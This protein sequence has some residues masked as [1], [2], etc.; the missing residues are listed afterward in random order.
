MEYIEVVGAKEHNLKNVDVKI[1]RNKFVVIT[2]LSG[3]GKSTLAFDIIYAEGQR[4]YMESLSSYARQFLGQMNKPKVESISGLSPA[5]SIE[6]KGVSKNPRSTVGTITEIYDYLRVFFARL[7]TIRCFK[8]GKVISAVSVD[9]ILQDIQKNLSLDDKFVILS[10]IVLSRKGEYKSLFESLKDKG[11]IRVRVDGEDKLLDEKITLKKNIK[12]NISVVIDRLIY[13]NEIESRLSESVETAL[14]L[15]DGLVEIEI[16]GKRVLLYSEKLHCIDCGIGFQSLSPRN[17]SF[18]SPYGAC[19]TCHG[20]GT[21]Y[22]FD[23]DLIVPDKT[24]SIDEDAIEIHKG[25]KSI[26]RQQLNSLAKHYKFSTTTPFNRLSSKIQKIIF[27]GSGDQEIKREYKSEKVV[28]NSVGT[29]EGVIPM[30]QRRYINTDSEYAREFYRKFM[31]ITD[32]PDCKGVRLKKESLSVTIDMNGKKGLN[33]IDVI[34]LS[35]TKCYDYFDSLDFKGEQKK[36]AEQLL[37][38]I[39]LRL[40]FLLDVGLGYLSLDR[41]ATTLSGG[42]SQRIRLATQVGSGLVGVLYVLDEPSIGLHQRDNDRLLSSLQNLRDL[43]NTVIVVEHDEDTIKSADYIVD[44]GPGAGRDGGMIVGEGDLK[45]FLKSKRSLTAKYLRKELEISTPVERKIPDK[46]NF[47]EVIGASQNNLKNFD[48]KIPLGLFC[49]VTGVS[50]SGKSTLVNEILYKGLKKLLYNSKEKPGKHKSIKNANKIDKLINITQ[51]PI[52]RTPRSN[53]ATYT[54]VFS[55]IRNLFSMTSEAKIRGYKPGRFSFNVKGGRC[56][57]C[58]G[59]GVKKIEMH[60]L[61][62]VFVVCEVCNGKRF[63]KE[64]LEVKY[65]H[66]NIFDVLEMTVNQAYDFFSKIPQIKHK[67]SVMKEVGLG[68]VKLGQPSNTLSGGEAQR[69]KLASELLKRS[70]G[71]TFYILDEPTTGL[72]FDDIKKLLNVINKLVDRGNSMLVIEHNLDVIKTA[73]YIIDLGPEGG[74]NGGT[75]IATGTPEQVSNNNKSYT[76]LYLKN[77]L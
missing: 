21:E 43:G 27:Y 39:K 65:K 75:V 60:F 47:I 5:I 12:H 61:S 18:N 71:Q 55:D 35:I 29:W 64:T 68:Y 57:S 32:C 26:F 50:G 42:E 76:G 74:D 15:S 63:N 2:G 17:F 67:L 46:N 4:R 30:L 7:G 36:I 44:L 48:I 16:L 24:K 33:I 11:F 23:E 10:P 53:P 9:Q 72:H 58:S 3:S 66:Q 22:I 45:S 6:Q 37:K 14:E 69:I 70:T 49:C 13:K 34:S 40:K 8:C 59:D 54:G 77:H 51:E 1:P 38:E 31:S 62:D 20:L 56:E 52:G 28:Y 19:E 25:E 73:D 41:S